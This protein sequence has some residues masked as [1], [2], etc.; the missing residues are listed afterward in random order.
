[1]TQSRT[2]GCPTRSNSSSS[3]WN[4]MASPIRWPSGFTATNCL[5]LPDAEVGEGVD[6]DVAEQ[7]QRVRALDEEV[8]H[9]VRLVEQGAGLQPGPLL[10]A[11]VGELGLHREGARREGEVP[12]QLDRAPGAGEGRGETLGGHGGRTFRRGTDRGTACP[13]APQDRHEPSSG[14][15][16]STVGSPAVGRITRMTTTWRPPGRRPDATCDVAARPSRDAAV[17]GR[18]GFVARPQPG[19]LGQALPAVRQ[20]AW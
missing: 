13:G 9:V 15:V 11:P 3:R 2:I 10:G 20:P 19:R 4:R 17:A 16:S 18:R 5:A 8:G 6:A 7:P 14:G 1:M 12:Q